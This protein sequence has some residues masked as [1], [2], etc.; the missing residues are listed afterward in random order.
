MNLVE[1]V[2]IKH[3]VIGNGYFATMQIPLLA[4]R[5]FGPQDTATSQRVAIISERMAK[6][7]FPAGINPIGHHYYTGWDPIP[8]T[9]VEVIGIVKDVKIFDLQ[10]RPQYVDYIPNPQHPWVYGTLAVRYEGDFKT[11]SNEVQQAIHTV[12]R[13]L[14]ISRITT[15]DEQVSRTITNQRLV[16][17]LSAFFGLLAVFL[18]CI[19]IYGLMSY[20]VSRR[21]NEIGIR[22]AIGASRGNVRWLVMREIVLLVAI[23][24]AVGVPVTL[25]GSHIVATLLF[26]LRGTDTTSLLGSVVALMLVSIMAGYLPARRAGQVDPMVAVRYE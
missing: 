13:T 15:V 7:L 16:A 10:E 25:A 24:I 19:G 5:T 22:I 3:N 18:S 4:G 26:V 11:I 17:Q 23:G 1:N 2:N 9:D 12:N 6:D 20:M 21:T 14:P 8:D